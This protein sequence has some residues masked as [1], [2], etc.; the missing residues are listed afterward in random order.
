MTEKGDPNH[1][2]QV[3]SWASAR[4]RFFRFVGNI[5]RF[6]RALHDVVDNHK[7]QQRL[8]NDLNNRVQRIEA[9][10]EIIIRLLE[11]DRKD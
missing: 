9:Q 7:R 3:T 2:G 6:E 11:R 4:D 5:V 10:Q 1:D 8:L